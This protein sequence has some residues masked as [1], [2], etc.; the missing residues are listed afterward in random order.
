MNRTK[1]IKRKLKAKEYEGAKERES[2][3]R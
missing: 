1:K 2:K 3:I